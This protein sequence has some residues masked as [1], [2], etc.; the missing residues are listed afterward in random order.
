M[1]VV[2]TSGELVVLL[3]KDKE[4]FVKGLQRGKAFKRTEIL[5]ARLEQKRSE[6][7]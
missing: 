2:L 6:G 3:Q 5:N 4:I 1:K 7:P